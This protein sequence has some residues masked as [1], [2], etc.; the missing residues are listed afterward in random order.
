MMEWRNRYLIIGSLFAFVMAASV[1]GLDYDDVTI[2]INITQIVSIDVNPNTVNWTGLAVGETGTPQY[3]TVTNV[4]SVNVTDL[5]ANIT[6]DNS[7][8][9][10]TGTASNYNAGEFVLL[11]TTSAGFYYVNKKNWNESVPGEVTSPTDWTEGADTGYFGI[12]RTASDGDV[13]QDYYYFT[14]MTGT[15]GNCV[16]ATSVILL[17]KEPKNVTSTGSVDFS[18]SA[19]YETISF[20]AGE[21]GADFSASHDLAG[22]CFMVSSDCSTV[23]MTRWNTDLDSGAYCS[24]DASFFTGSDLEPGSHTEFYLEPK[25]PNGVPDGDVSQG[26]LTIIATAS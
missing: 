3:F 5:R 21:N 14:N 13:G 12:V 22:Y 4:G 16:S 24:N 15:S 26:T 23:T 2:G 8:P 20:G 18:N 19:N 17:G 10:G 1:S 25:I 6:N 9:Y 11:N 7:N